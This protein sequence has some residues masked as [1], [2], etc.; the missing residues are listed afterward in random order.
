MRIT[1]ALTLLGSA[2]TRAAC[3]GG[4]GG[5]DGGNGPPSQVLGSITLSP[6][7]PSVT[8]GQKVTLTPRALDTQGG[9][10]NGASGYSFTSAANAIA[11]VGAT[12]GEVTGV[13]PGQAQITASL[14]R[15]GVTRTAN[16][17]VT[18]TNGTFPATAS[19]TATS[20]ATFNPGQVD[21][22]RGG[23]VTWTFEMLHNVNFS[24][25]G[26]PQNI[27]NKES[28]TESRTFN[29]AGEFDY[30][31]TMHSGMRGTVVVH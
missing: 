15:D 30:E 23:S 20:G 19:V 25:T 3:G 26:A 24:G 13:A 17:T 16:T 29:T 9:T 7:N 18:V 8:V 27:P 14:T 21:I 22:A 2:A 12:T 4:G 1:R 6:P 11:T 5:D 28:G 31:C 10:I